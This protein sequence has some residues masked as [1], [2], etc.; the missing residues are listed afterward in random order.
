M[1]ISL[2]AFAHSPLGSGR[3][4]PLPPGQPE[5]YAGHLCSPLPLLIYPNR[6][7]ESWSSETTPHARHRVER[8]LIFDL[9]G[10]LT[11][12]LS[13]LT[14]TPMHKPPHRWNSAPHFQRGT[15]GQREG[16]APLLSAFLAGGRGSKRAETEPMTLA[17]VS[18]VIP[19]C[20]TRLTHSPHPTKPT[21]PPTKVT[22]TVR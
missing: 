16:L 3:R 13:S 20:Q 6:A 9:M 10:R 11:T 22:E 14:L 15:S 19:V 4:L 5:R 17:S 2:L 12:G 18:L 21:T 1:K 8:T 7:Q